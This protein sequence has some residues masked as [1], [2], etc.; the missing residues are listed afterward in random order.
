[1]AAL[2]QFRRVPQCLDRSEV[3]TMSWCEQ[4]F[5]QIQPTGNQ[6]L[7]GAVMFSL[8]VAVPPLSWL[9]VFRESTPSV[10]SLR[11]RFGWKSEV[12]MFE[13]YFFW[14]VSIQ[15]VSPLFSD[16][17]FTFGFWIQCNLF[18][19][20][21]D[22]IGGWMWVLFPRPPFRQMLL[23]FVQ[24]FVSFQ[25][26]DLCSSGFVFW[27]NVMTVIEPQS[28]NGDFRKVDTPRGVREPNFHWIYSLV[29]WRVN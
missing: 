26:C 17:H 20:H 11:P 25:T 19:N 9:C 4:G 8:R 24:C 22:R 3:P 27:G 29:V 2:V 23:Y 5:L 14:P 15:F 16:S 1:M 10:S 13:I 6:K 18:V 21:L 7:L 28:G 12:S